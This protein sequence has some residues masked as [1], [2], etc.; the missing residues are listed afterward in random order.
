MPSNQELSLFLDLPEYKIN[1]ALIAGM[2]VMSIDKDE[3]NYIYDTI[4][5]ESNFDDN[6][7][8]RDSLNTLSDEEK[9]IIIERYFNDM[10]QCEVAKKL[11]L[12][13]VKVSRYEKKGLNKMQNYFGV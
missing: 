4:G 6:I 5:S 3:N 7:M 1:E 10:T 8:I 2:E 9:Q 11:S 13:Q 12:T